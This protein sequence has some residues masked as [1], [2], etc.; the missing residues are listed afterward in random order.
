MRTDGGLFD[1][2]AAGPELL[3]ATGDAA[4][5]QAMLDAEAALASAQAD[6]GIVPAGAA[7]SVAAACRA[8]AFDAATI[9]ARA[10]LGG[11]PVIPLVAALRA[12]VP[13]GARDWVHHGATSQDILDT[14]AMLVIQRSLHVVDGD[15]AALAGACA[16]LAERHRRTVMAARTLLQHALPTTF[17]LKAAGWLVA[18]VKARRGLTEAP[19]P[20]QLGGA[21]GTLASLGPRG[22]EVADAM[23]CRLGLAA[24]LLPWHTNRLP[25]AEVACRLGMAAGVAAKIA[26]DVALLMQSE[27]AEAS[28]PAAPGRGGSSTLPQK[29]NPVGCVAALAAA[30]HAHALVG[31]V[32]AG[33]AQEHERAAGAW[34]AEWQA[35]T[36]LLRAAGG[37]IA[38]TREVVAGLE[39][40]PA[41]MRA[42]LDADG[43]LLLA[44]RVTL[45]LAQRV[46]YAEARGAVET[47]VAQ[48]QG[49]GATFASA[50][51]ACTPFT[52]SE[53]RELLDASS[54]LGAGD[55][56]IDRAL[57]AFHQGA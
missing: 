42:N 51:R 22:L 26:T 17:G 12:A 27:V 37:A 40:D 24:P 39:V 14:A 6:A 34:Q 52:E 33:M 15:L 10:R 47:A 19:L 49:A 53:I 48:A 46:G 13:K 16:A 32:L 54:Y 5:L 35:L 20:L 25:V 45:A 2:I 21:A 36:D 55:A 31:L 4:W 50:L 11:N 23:A 3:A 1:Q 18:V 28:E 44:E 7:A 41:R 38:R 43:G 57:A 9:G 56:M 29:R 30:R 8:E